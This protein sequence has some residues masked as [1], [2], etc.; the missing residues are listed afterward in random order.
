MIERLSD[1]LRLALRRRSVQEVPLGEELE[2]LDAYLEIMKARFEDSLSVELEVPPAARR[3]LVP[4]LILQ[5]LVENSV[6]YCMSDPARQ[7]R[8]RISATVAGERLRLAIEDNGPGLAAEARDAVG[9]GVGLSTTAD[10]LRWLH[11]EEQRLE[12]KNLDGGGLRLTLEFP[13]RVAAPEERGA[14]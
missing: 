8:I 10:R 7:G 6:T 14:A 5:P 11:G 2:F 1:F 12:F 4:H 13:L 3:A 9:R